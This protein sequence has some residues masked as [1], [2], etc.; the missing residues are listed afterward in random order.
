MLTSRWAASSSR[1]LAEVLRL[2][3]GEL[4]HRHAG[5]VLLQV[6]VDRRDPRSHLAV[7]RARAAA[8]PG[9]EQD[10]E[11]Q[12]GERHEREAPVEG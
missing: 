11:R 3:A 9:G 7:D 5:Q 10:H 2:G 8:E 1:K 4:D 6:C 12:H